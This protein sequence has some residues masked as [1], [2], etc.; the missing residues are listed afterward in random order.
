MQKVKEWIRKPAV[1]GLF[2]PSSHSELEH[3]INQMLAAVTKQTEAANAFAIIVPHA[4]YVYSGQVAAYAYAT[5]P[6]H[7]QSVVLLGAN[8]RLENYQGISIYDRGIFRTPLGDVEVDTQLCEKLKKKC[9]KLEFIPDAHLIEHSIEVQI[10]FLQK[11]LPNVP[12]VP[13][14]LS[15]YRVSTCEELA[16]A[17]YQTLDP[18]IHLVIASTDLSHYYPDYVATE[19]DAKAIQQ[20]EK[21]DI[22]N[23]I[24]LHESGQTELCG[25]GPVLTTLYYVKHHGQVN[26]HILKYAH[27]GEV[28][29]DDS[30]VVGYVAVQFIKNK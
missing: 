16:L 4:G 17:L 23:F 8:H 20:I 30:Q 6:K 9:P 2:Y 7:I 10:P 15:D 5:L 22:S 24:Q 25:Y 14:V 26:T 21:L 1:S 29:H 27:S 18:D 13:I 11:A 19:M 3:M 12:I 28:S